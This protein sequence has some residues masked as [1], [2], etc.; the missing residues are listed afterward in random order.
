MNNDKMNKNLEE[1]KDLEKEVASLNKLIE[2]RLSR[3]MNVEIQECVVD[4]LNLI[5]G[6]GEETIYFW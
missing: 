6:R 4:M 3:N 2:E 1:V 5:F